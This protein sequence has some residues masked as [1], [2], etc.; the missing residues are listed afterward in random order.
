MSLRLQMLMRGLG[1]L[2][3]LACSVA[4]LV[5]EKSAP[6]ILVKIEAAIN[7]AG[8]FWGVSV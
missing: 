7:T 5:C 1:E 6:P 8:V 3:L 4:D 2:S